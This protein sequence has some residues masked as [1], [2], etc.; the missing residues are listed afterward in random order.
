VS[1]IR[2]LYVLVLVKL[3]GCRDLGKKDENRH[4]YLHE[5]ALS[6]PSSQDKSNRV[7]IQIDPEPGVIVLEN[8]LFFYTMDGH[9]GG[10]CDSEKI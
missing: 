1:C 4:S 3:D 5:S 9:G 10:R 2:P 7:T 6:Q 8:P